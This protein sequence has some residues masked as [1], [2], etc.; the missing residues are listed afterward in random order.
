VKLLYLLLCEHAHEEADE[1][2]HVTGVFR[3]LY[4]PGFPAEHQATLVIG[5][6]W[7]AGEAGDKAFRIDLLDPGRSPVITASGHTTVPAEREPGGPPPLSRLLL[8]ID[9]MIFPVPGRYEFELTLGEE[10]IEG[11]PLYLIED[12]SGR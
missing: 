8:P 3:R 10:R 11:A 2:L 6:E 12:H 9:R 7:D 4:A 1:R 5:I